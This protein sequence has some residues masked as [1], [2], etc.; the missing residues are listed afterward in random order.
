MCLNTVFLFVLDLGFGRHVVPHPPSIRTHNTA[1]ATTCGNKREYMRKGG[2]KLEQC[3][4]SG[5]AEKHGINT[6][7]FLNKNNVYKQCFSMLHG[8]VQKENCV[9]TRFCHGFVFGRCYATWKNYVYTRFYRLW[10]KLCLYTIFSAPPEMRHCSS[11][12]PP[13]VPASCSR[14]LVSTSCS[15]RPLAWTFTEPLKHNT[16]LVFADFFWKI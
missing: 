14:L 11:F 8:V 4:I 15:H 16:Y 1:T 10:K 9:Y 13:L 7:S 5:R 6:N 12:F 3:R 2:R